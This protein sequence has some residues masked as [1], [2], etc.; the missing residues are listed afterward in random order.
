VQVLGPSGDGR[1]V[2]IVGVIEHA[3]ASAPWERSTSAAAIGQLLDD[4]VTRRPAW[5]HDAAC[6]EHDP[7][8]F[9]PA[10]GE[11]T[12]PAK[13]I[14]RGCLVRD[15]CYAFVLEVEPAGQRH[16]VWAATTT[17]Q[18]AK[19]MTL[20]EVDAAAAASAAL[21]ERRRAEWAAMRAREPAVQAG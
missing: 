13:A 20:A 7:A 6:A 2:D 8:L 16:G 14:C 4:L 1:S 12:E 3:F 10:K 9:H 17:V 18:R 21:D 5:M 19:G 15:E 11:P